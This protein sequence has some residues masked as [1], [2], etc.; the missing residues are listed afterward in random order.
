MKRLSAR[1]LPFLLLVLLSHAVPVL[2]KGLTADEAKKFLH[3]SGLRDLIASL[4]ESM[5]QQL[6]AKRLSTNSAM[7]LDKTRQAIAKA[8]QK[9]DGEKIAL[10]YLSQDTRAEDLAE[11]LKF[12]AS[13]LGQRISAEE[14]SASRPEAQIAMQAHAQEKASKPVDQPRIEMLEKLSSALNADQVVIQLIK[15]VYFSV[16]DAVSVI[17]PSKAK[18]LEQHM[19]QEWQSMEPMLRQQFSQF[20]LMGADYSYRNLSDENL[21]A[22]I[23]FLNSESGQAYWQVGV[24]IID[25]YIQGFV[26]E[27]VAELSN[28]K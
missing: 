7:S 4:P 21:L 8:A 14:R 28:A 25:L 1:I 5:N 6:D 20:M 19:A 27:L 10:V 12:L 15:G 23:A 3:D 22:Y 24:D 18:S 9:V 2:A 16:L 26:S 17:K 11:A 13:E